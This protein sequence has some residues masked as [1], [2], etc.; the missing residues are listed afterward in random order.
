[1]KK[2]SLIIIALIVVISSCKEKITVTD[3]N[4]TDNITASTVWTADNVY[5]VDGLISV[6]DNQVLTIMPGT[7]VKFT[8]GSEFDIGNGDYG[9]IKAIGTAEEPI[10]FTSAAAIP[11]KGDWNGFWLYDGANSCDFAYCVFEYGGGYSEEQGVMN[12]RG[13]EASFNF[14][15]FTQSGGYGIELRDCGFTLFTNNIISDNFNYEIKMNAG[16]VHTLGT[17]NIYDGKSILVAGG[18]LDVPGTFVWTNQGVPYFVTET[19][20]IG[21]TAGTTLSLNAGI[22]LKMG[23]DTEIGVGYSDNFGSI[24]AQGTSDNPIIITSGS[25]F[26]AKGDWYGIWLYESTMPGTIFNNCEISY[27]GGYSNGGNIVLRQ[28]IGNN[29]TVSNSTISYSEEYGIYKNIESG[30]NPTLSNI[31][32]IDNTLGDT[33]F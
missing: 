22:T 29:V 10:V 28:D 3:L 2:L 1:M 7:V 16:Y 19:M 20:N 11:Q 23:K 13:T 24:V 21:S 33:N 14:C 8:E 15:T 18:Y 17:N 27:G 26:P 25:A 5:I 6:T 12:L 31:T 4:I 9:T 30:G 32:Y